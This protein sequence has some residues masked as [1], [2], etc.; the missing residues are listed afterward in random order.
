[1]KKY[2]A[3]LPNGSRGDAENAEKDTIVDVFLRVLRASAYLQGCWTGT[4]L[5]ISYP[6]EAVLELHTG[7]CSSPACAEENGRARARKSLVAEYGPEPC[8]SP[9]LLAQVNA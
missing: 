1:M 5:R 9:Y 2:S 6:L 7:D 3:G 4:P 8:N